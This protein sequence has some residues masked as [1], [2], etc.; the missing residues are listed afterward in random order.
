[1]HVSA[2]FCR[3]CA[4]SRDTKRG[5]CTHYKESKLNTKLKLALELML[6]MPAGPRRRDPGWHPVLGCP[7]RASPPTRLQAGWR[8]CAALEAREA[9][10]KTGLRTSCDTTTWG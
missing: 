2:G 8:Q 1:M 10:P 9:P 5:A 4:T 6:I 7:Q 3:A